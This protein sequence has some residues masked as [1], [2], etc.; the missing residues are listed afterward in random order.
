MYDT[1]PCGVSGPP[2]P[3]SQRAPSWD[4]RKTRPV[5]SQGSGSCLRPICNAPGDCWKTPICPAY[6]GIAL[7]LSHCDVRLCTAHS[8]GFRAPC[9]C[10]FSNSLQSSSIST[11]S[12]Q[13]PGKGKCA[14]VLHDAGLELSFFVHSLFVYLVFTGIISSNT[15]L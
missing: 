14:P 10:R 13:I 11:G 4:T 8:S 7:I 15:K 6:G 5:R 1:T 12:K 3:S 2:R 9:I